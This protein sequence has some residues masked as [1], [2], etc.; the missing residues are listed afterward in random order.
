[1]FLTSIVRRLKT[2]ERGVAL[3]AVIGVMVVG[4]LLTSLIMAAILGGIRFTTSTKAGVQSQA[5]ADA[6]IDVAHAGLEAGNCSAVGGV[7][8][9]AAGTS[10]K[11]SAQVWHAVTAGDAW[12]SGCPISTSTV[13][14]VVSTG[15]ADTLGVA[16]ASGND[17]S[18]VEAVYTVPVK[19][20]GLVGTGAAVYSYASTGFVDTTLSAVSGS[21]PSIQVRS[22]DLTCG[23]S[24][25]GIVNLV[26]SNGNLTVNGSCTVS[27]N[28]WASGRAT[29]SS[30]SIPGNVIANGVTMT[31]GTVGGSVWSTL[32]L[33]MTGGT[34]SGNATANSLSMNGAT[35]LI[36]GNAWINGAASVTKSKITGTLTAKSL[37][38]SGGT[39]GKTTLVPA[40][41]GTSPY[42]APGM[43]TVPGWVDFA[44]NPA[45]WVGFT[46]LAISGNCDPTTIAN[47]VKTLSKAPGIL[48][49]RGCTNGFV[50]TQTLT[51]GKDLVIIANSFD[52]K[53]GAHLTPSNQSVTSRVWM[54]T[55]DTVAD[56][57]P[58][59]PTGSSFKIGDSVEVDPPLQFMVYSPCDVSVGKSFHD[60][61]QI[62]SN[63]SSL[64]ASA[65]LAYIAIGLPGVDLNTGTISNGTSSGSTL[66]L[67]TLRNVSTGG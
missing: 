46:V 2:E 29:V 64:S 23:T 12:V 9:S 65:E 17:V 35:A 14:R 21:I 43:P 27:G 42:I 28:A 52:L 22:G 44:Y 24:V 32:D 26:V 31:G 57:K 7:Y 63:T 3:A 67:S 15:T 33:T 51:I 36:S 11:Y 6:G 20:A 58:T 41:P 38:N 66:T 37:F 61:G 1:M 8:A 16:S 50:M 4:L 19:V 39:I 10:P 5:A 30:G 55:P 60:R 54:I 48:D 53:A 25:V 45:D 34:I 49:A 59:C 40:G 18:Y 47:A 13:V 62:Y 56:Q